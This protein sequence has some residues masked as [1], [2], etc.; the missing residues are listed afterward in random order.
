MVLDKKGFFDK[1]NAIVGGNTSD[2]AL[3]FL[4]DMQDTYNDMEK[5]IE[6]ANGQD[7][8]KKYEEND[9]LWRAKYKHRF[10]SGASGNPD[11][12]EVENSEEAQALKRAETIKIED[13][14]STDTKGKE[15]Q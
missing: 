8:K 3:S 6:D 2:E 13:L 4:D 7:W 10:F 1:V 9:A 15:L 11:E 14:F 12:M 5:R